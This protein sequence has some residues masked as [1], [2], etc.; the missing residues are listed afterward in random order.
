[1]R[2]QAV[3]VGE[4]GTSTTDTVNAQAAFSPIQFLQVS[5][6][7]SVQRSSGATGSSSSDGNTYYYSAGVSATYQ[8]NKWLRASAAYTWSLEDGGG[9]NGRILHNL[10]SISLTAAYPFRID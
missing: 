3:T 1:M 8:L 5:L 9:G 10:L 7:T 4:S 6:G 2:T